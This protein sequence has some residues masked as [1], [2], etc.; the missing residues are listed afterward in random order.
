MTLIDFNVTRS[1]KHGKNAHIFVESNL[2]TGQ[3]SGYDGDFD[4]DMADGTTLGM[5]V[6]DNVPGVAKGVW[7]IDGKYSIDFDRRMEQYK[8]RATE[9]KAAICKLGVSAGA[10]VNFYPMSIGKWNEKGTVKDVVSCEFEMAARGQYNNGI[11]ALSPKTPI[12]SASGTGP[13]DDNTLYGGATTFGAIAWMWVFD[14]AGGT[15]PGITMKMQH[16]TTSGGTY[17]DLITFGAVTAPGIYVASA[18]STTTVNAF[19][20]PAYTITGSPTGIQ[21]MV[22]FARKYDPTA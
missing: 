20:Q 17:T 2:I 1:T 11:I 8:N 6:E 5:E 15:T 4:R 21:A 16:C 18:P 3:V 7:K 9:V 22:G 13:I 10:P 14:I 19:T 12:S